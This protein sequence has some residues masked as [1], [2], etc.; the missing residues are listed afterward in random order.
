MQVFYK[1]DGKYNFHKRQAIRLI[2][3]GNVAA[4]AYGDGQVYLISRGQ[5]KRIESHFCGA[6]DCRCAAGAVELLDPDKAL[7]GIRT[8]WCTAWP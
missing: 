6:T 4:G 3:S 1:P 2:V 8:G 5:A 7:F